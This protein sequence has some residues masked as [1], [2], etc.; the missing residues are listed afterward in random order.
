MKL[1][2]L[3]LLLVVACSV[4]GCSRSDKG[5][6]PAGPLELTGYGPMVTAGTPFNI[7]ESG[8]SAMWALTR[9]AT[10][11]TV[12]V[13]NET[14]LASVPAKDGK[15]VTAFVPNEVF[16][17]AGEFPMHLLDVK[18]GAKSNEIKFVVK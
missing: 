16:A 6:A 12:L 5:S 2:S 3:A 10:Q 18:T 7:Q 4:V 14:R 13:I 9:N 1:R 15:T 17:R 8:Q 11:S